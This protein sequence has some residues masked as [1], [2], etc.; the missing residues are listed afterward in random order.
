[1]PPGGQKELSSNVSY[2]VMSFT[3]HSLDFLPRSQGTWITAFL[4][5]PKWPVTWST[6]WGNSCPPDKMA[7][8][9]ERSWTQGDKVCVPWHC[10]FCPT[11]T[12]TTNGYSYFNLEILLYYLQIIEFLNWKSSEGWDVIDLLK[13]TQSLR[14]HSLQNPSKSDFHFIS[15]PGSNFLNWIIIYT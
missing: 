11:Y 10:G 2:P 6:A 4:L 7:K 5:S 3:G 12:N 8:I 1:M 14:E 9:R 13:P 15:S